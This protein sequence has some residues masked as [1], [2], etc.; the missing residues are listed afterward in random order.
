MI[1]LKAHPFFSEHSYDTKWGDLLNQKSPLEAKPK[2]SS[3]PKNNTD[4]IEV[5]K[6]ND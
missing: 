3:R 4:E 1:H 6:T 5:K 2:L